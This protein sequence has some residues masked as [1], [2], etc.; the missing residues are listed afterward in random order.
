[1]KKRLFVTELNGFVGQHIQ[2]R[3]NAEASK[4]ALLPT[5]FRY[6]LDRNHEWRDDGRM[7]PVTN[8]RNENFVGS[9]W[10][11]AICTNAR[12]HTI[13]SEFLS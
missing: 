8:N 4:C 9:S 11:A 6:D 12:P 1:L 13:I 5:T 3:L 7:S 2:S 10:L